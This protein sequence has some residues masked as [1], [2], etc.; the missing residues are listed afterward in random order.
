MLALEH[1]RSLCRSHIAAAAAVVVASVSVL[2][3]RISETTRMLTMSA[4]TYN[5][6]WPERK[7]HLQQ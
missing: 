4:E 2:T 1:S 7:A 5:L 3:F 6:F